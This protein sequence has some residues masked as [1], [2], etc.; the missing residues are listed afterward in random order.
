MSAGPEPVVPGVPVDDAGAEAEPLVVVGRTIGGVVM[1]IV[2]LLLALGGAIVFFVAPLVAPFTD[3]RLWNLLWD[4]DFVGAIV[5]G[6]GLV[7][8]FIGGGLVQRARRRKLQMLIDPSQITNALREA[9]KAGD[10]PG[11]SRTGTVPPTIL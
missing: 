1:V 4:L 7:L 8:A 11:E 9:G 6:L 5:A 3:D 10:V 2:G